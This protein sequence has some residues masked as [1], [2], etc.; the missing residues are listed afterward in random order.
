MFQ[1]FYPKKLEHMDK[2]NTVAETIV[3]SFNN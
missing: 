3:N 1:K 2:D